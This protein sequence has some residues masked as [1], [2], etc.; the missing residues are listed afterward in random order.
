MYFMSFQIQ[1]TEITK[2]IYFAKI[3]KKEIKLYL[4]THSC[5]RIHVYH[6]TYGFE[7]FFLLKIFQNLL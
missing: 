3:Q 2:K 4:L 1:K 6:Y 5:L 7:C